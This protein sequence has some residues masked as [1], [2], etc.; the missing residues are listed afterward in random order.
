MEFEILEFA[1]TERKE[2]LPK[3]NSKFG[4]KKEVSESCVESREIVYAADPWCRYSG[5]PPL[6]ENRVSCE[7]RRKKEERERD[8]VPSLSNN[9]ARGKKMTIDR[10]ARIYERELD[11]DEN[12][13]RS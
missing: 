7:R 4:E 2:S 13:R 10:G 6:E 12:E 3:L 9:V 1:E 8:L 5:Y 11:P